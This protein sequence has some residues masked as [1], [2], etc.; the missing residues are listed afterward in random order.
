M[1]LK[2]NITFFVTTLVFLFFLMAGCGIYYYF[3]EPSLS[4]APPLSSAISRALHY[5]DLTQVTPAQEDKTGRDFAGNW[6][7]YFHVNQQPDIRIR[8]ISPF[9]ATFIHHSLTHITSEN[10]PVLE[11]LSA[12]V[13]KAQK[14]R[15]AAI[16]LMRRFE[17]QPRSH[18]AGTFGFWPSQEGSL[19]L[20]E[21]LFSLFIQLQLKGPRL[22]GTRVPT[23]IDC[24][25]PEFAIPHD[26][27]STST[28][29]AA[30][31]E[32]A[33][34]DEES[35]TDI[36]FERFF[37][38]WR[39][40]GHIPLRLNPKW[41]PPASGAFLTWLAYGFSQD[42]PVEND[43]D[44]VVNAN[45]LF[46]L[47]RYGHLDIPGVEDAITLINKATLAGYHN[48]EVDRISDYYPNNFAFHYC[49]SRAY[50]EGPVPGLKPSVERLADELEASA[51]RNCEGAVFWNQGDPHLNTAF[52]ILT[53]L[54]A[55]RNGFLVNAAVEYLES[56]QDPSFGNWKEAVFFIGRP[57]SGLVIRWSSSALTTAIALEALCRYRLAQN[58]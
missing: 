47:A 1:A 12:D 4:P 46:A 55:G 44:L 19:N 25:P 20:N 2:R 27:D 5:L 35:L 7:Q 40:L 58:N 42:R 43:V 11:I 41:L 38:D 31:L 6:P 33:K 23:N 13:E 48:S 50:Y 54:N 51:K 52:A 56:Q 16:S 9:M 57:E 3:P 30:L 14:M 34:V 49:V 15:S 53:L 10:Q 37:S 18:G 28:V 24:F 45:V 39:D 32:S 26:A 8:D 29:Y 17:A 22:R 36:H 21:R